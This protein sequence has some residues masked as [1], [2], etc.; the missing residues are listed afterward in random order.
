MKKITYYLVL[1]LTIITIGCS[2]KD[3]KLDSIRYELKYKQSSL[4][5]VIIELSNECIVEI[6]E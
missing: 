6:E 1:I 3:T 2:K 5:K 4:E